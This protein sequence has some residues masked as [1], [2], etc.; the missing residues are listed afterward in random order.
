MV[1]FLR[2]NKNSE[3]EK[4]TNAFFGKTVNIKETKD[5]SDY[6]NHQLFNQFKSIHWKSKTVDE[7]IAIL[8][9]IENREAEEHNRPPA[10][11]VQCYSNNLGGYIYRTNVIEVKL[12]NN[13]FEVLDSLF[14]ESE[15]ANQYRAP[16]NEVSF[17][18]NDRKLMKIEDMTSA[19]GYK[20]HYK[21]YENQ[22]YDLMTSEIDANNAAFEKVSSLKKEYIDEKNYKKYLKDR[23]SYFNKVENESNLKSSMK[24]EALLDTIYGAY[25]RNEISEKEY[26]DLQQ[27]ITSDKNYDHCAER[28]TKINEALRDINPRNEESIKSLSLKGISENDDLREA[29]HIINS[30]LQTNDDD[31]ETEDVNNT[32][33]LN[34]LSEDYSGKQTFDSTQP[35]SQN[36]F[37]YHQISF[38]DSKIEKASESQIAAKQMLTAYMFE[39]NYG[40]ADYAEYS[41]DP[42][43]RQLHMAAYPDS[44]LPPLRSPIN[45]NKIEK[46]S[47]SQIAAKQM[48]TAYMFE[49][50]YGR[51]DYAEYSQDPFWR[52]LHM[53]AFPDSELPPL[54]SPNA[55]YDLKAKSVS[56]VPEE[57][58]DT[59]K[60]KEVEED[61]KVEETTDVE[62]ESKEREVEE[63][64]KSEE[65]GAK[66]VES[67]EAEAEEETEAEEVETEK[68]ESEES[69][70]EEE[71]EAE[72]VKTEEVESEEV[73]SEEV[74]SEDAE[75]E[76]ETEAE[77][78]ETEEVESEESEAEEETEE[79]ESEEAEAEE[80]TE[81]EEVETEEVESEEAETEEETEAEEVETEEV[82]SEEAEA[83]EETEAE[84]VETEEVESEEAEAEEETEA[85]EVETEEVESEEVEAE[86]ETEA[87]EV[88]TEEVESEESEVEEETE[89][90]EV[91]T[92]EVESEEV[93]AEEEIET[94]E[95][96]TEEVES[97]ETK[98]EE[99]E[100]EKETEVEQAETEEVE[101][102]EI[103]SEEE[104]ETEDIDFG[105]EEATEEIESEDI[106]SAMYEDDNEEY[107][108]LNY[109][110]DSTMLEDLDNTED[111]TE[112][113]DNSEM[114]DDLGESED[115]DSSMSDSYD[116]SSSSGE[117]ISSDGGGMDSDAGMDME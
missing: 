63:Q 68:V 16:I 15:H 27:L 6:S 69:V 56:E 44:E 101:S 64:I 86:E 114:I 59:D 71:T 103:E 76:E 89:A 66:E 54:R 55:Y 29:R 94:E 109:E 88:E 45:D 8:Q 33:S 92:E 87:E 46:A 43:W 38:N 105:E 39:H 113:E 81:A 78:V 12:V 14:H 18:E 84:E 28:R 9:E 40:R 41:Q 21:K 24:R 4:K 32:T 1:L 95:V 73:E 61:T 96:E 100:A 79:V 13:Q 102:E 5:Y 25:V 37:D 52:Q 98:V 11:V 110:E 75:A 115:M 31:F 30:I 93:E 65:T 35:A 85:E 80:E 90:E 108:D 58:N 36:E 17:S 111:V 10:K 42:F 99:T 72:E 107:E 91:E 112:M 49:H 48:L 51:A 34:N 53:A 74:E 67:E 23:K 70:A 2:G 82:E 7:K 3:P 83:E 19:D 50:N 22:L 106:D 47:E 77:E 60:K 62:V 116:Y 97:E 26:Q 20:S 117:D 104:I 57:T